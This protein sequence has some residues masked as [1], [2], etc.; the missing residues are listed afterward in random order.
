VR[1]AFTKRAGG[2]H[3]IVVTDRPH[4]PDVRRARHETGQAIPHDLVHLVVESALGIDDGFWGAIAAGATFGGFEATDRRAHRTPGRKVLA[5]RGP[6]LGAAEL[7]VAGIYRTWAGLP[8]HRGLP[9]TRLGI[10][11]ARR[12][13]ACRALDEAKAMWDALPVDASITRA[14]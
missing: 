12:D 6:A 10:D 11:E 14:W 1:V 5:R 9:E 13:R 7:L 4:G 3:E 8:V 2:D